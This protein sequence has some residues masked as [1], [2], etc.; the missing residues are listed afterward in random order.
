MKSIARLGWV[1]IFLLLIATLINLF[2]CSNTPQ[3]FHS[4]DITGAEW[5]NKL[6]L[7]DV[8][9]KQIN[10]SQFKG[11]VIT[12]FFGFL[13][14]PDFCPNHLNKMV[15]L[16]KSLNNK[17]LVTIF[18]SVDP[19]RDT[20]E[21]MKNY[22]ASFDPKFIGIIP[23]EEELENLK[24]EFKL[25]VNKVIQPGS[26]NYLIDHYTYTYIFDTKGDLRLLSPASTRQ[27]DLLSDILILLD[28]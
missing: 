26:N 11:K 21:N 22:L 12:L 10:L 3:V 7:K 18:I 6:T 15:Y 24:K 27:E 14:C 4:I 28:S 19:E 8:D 17:N 16:K 5:G 20:K 1:A 13:S 9:S 23:S 25:V 2:G